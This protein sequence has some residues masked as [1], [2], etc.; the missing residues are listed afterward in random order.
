MLI[1]EHFRRLAYLSRNESEILKEVLSKQT[2]EC[3]KILNDQKKLEK[4][5]KILA[6]EVENVIKNKI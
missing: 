4:D 1:Y 2:N 6:N 5:W 3:E